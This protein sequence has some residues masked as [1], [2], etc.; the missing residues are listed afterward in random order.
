MSI[1]EIDDTKRW[2]DRAAVAAS[3]RDSDFSVLAKVGLFAGE[4]RLDELER[5]DGVARRPVP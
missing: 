4:L 3:H 5:G 2:R 1:R